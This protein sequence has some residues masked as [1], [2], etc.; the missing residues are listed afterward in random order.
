MSIRL[1]QVLVR[2]GLISDEQLVQV[3]ELQVASGCRIGTLL[4]H[5]ELVSLEDL[6]LALSMQHG[7]PQADRARLEAVSPEVAAL[8]PAELCDELKVLPFHAEGRTLHL[9]MRDPIRGIAGKVAC[10]LKAT[11]QVY[12]VP[13]LRLAYY[14]EKQ[15]GIP[16]DPRLLRLPDGQE[17]SPGRRTYLAPTLAAPVDD[18]EQ[19]EGLIY[20]DQYTFD[21]S[22]TPAM[23]RPIEALRRSLAAAESGQA[24]VQLLV[25]PALEQ[26]ARSVLFW[27]RDTFAIAC[28]SSETSLGQRRLQQLVVSLQA[29]SLLQVAFETGGGV[30]APAA[31][32]PLCD[33]IADTLGWPRPSDVCVVPVRYGERVVNLLC[34]QAEEPLGARALEDLRRLASMAEEAYQRLVRAAFRPGDASDSMPSTG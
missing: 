5:R 25:R 13:E 33:G 30:M 31:N 15:H 12:V 9:A 21:A 23:P 22:A 18:W 4:V 6:G 24:V 2:R 1:G 16:R 20:L 3:L 19:S 26:A 27:V 29:P 11:V 17:Q 34:T 28:A 14:L 7:V 10:A 8:L 32:D